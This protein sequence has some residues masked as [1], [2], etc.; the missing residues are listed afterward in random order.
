MSAEPVEAL[1]R[2]LVRAL[3]DATN[4]QPQWRSI[5]GLSTKA[6][7]KAVVAFAVEKG[8]ILLEYGHSACLTEAGR[9]LAKKR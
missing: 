8:W 7:S 6:N 5:S 2:H 4:G 1:A 9:R 3:Y